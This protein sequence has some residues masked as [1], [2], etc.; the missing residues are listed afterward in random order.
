[1]N[2]FEIILKLV[3]NNFVNNLL[4][5]HV[6]LQEDLITLNEQEKRAADE[7]VTLRERLQEMKAQLKSF[8]DVETL[9]AQVG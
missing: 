6:Q 9:K 2:I 7:I 5:G 3:L 1:V 4:T 8:G